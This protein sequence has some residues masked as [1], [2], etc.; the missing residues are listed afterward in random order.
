MSKAREL[1]KLPNYVLSTVA[2][3]KLSVGK[4]QGDKAFVGGYY[5]DG[6]GGGGDFYWD[7]VSVETDN[8]GTIFQVTGT[9]TGRWKRIYSGSVNV[10]WFGA[11]GD[12]A[13]NDTAAIQSSMQHLSIFIPIGKY[14]VTTPLIPLSK[15]KIYG[16]GRNTWYPYGAVSFPDF[17][18]SALIT[19]G[20]GC[21]NLDGKS[22]VS[23][24][25]ISIEDLSGVQSAYG[26]NAGYVVGSYGIKIPNTVSIQI[27]DIS[28][29]GLEY[30]IMASE[31]IDEAEAMMFR[32]DNFEASDCKCV[33][34]IGNDTSSG[35]IARDFQ[36]LNCT[37]ALHCGT[38][39]DVSNTDGMQCTNLRLFQS[40]YDAVK[41]KN[42]PFVVMNGITI[43]ESKERNIIIDGCNY[44]VMSAMLLSRA[45]GYSITTPWVVKSAIEIIN[46]NSIKFDGAIEHPA[47]QAIVLSSCNGANID[48]T[49]ETPFYTNGMSTVGGEGAVSI[50]SSTG[51][52]L[53]GV[54]TGD[55]AYIYGVK[56]DYNSM[57]EI[58]GYV[59]TPKYTANSKVYS[60]DT[61][62]QLC[63]NYIYP[64]DVALGAGGGASV[65]FV[66]IYIPNGK[67]LVT[68]GGTIGNKD[69]QF[70]ILYGAGF[71]F[72][73]GLIIDE[74]MYSTTDERKEIYANS[75]GS[76]IELQLN[77]WDRNPTAGV[78]TILA[79]TIYSLNFALE[80]I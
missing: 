58:D 48:F 62:N 24:S 79:G 77:L 1:S 67:K 47:G 33:V 80:N 20:N 70:R 60:L 7:A 45:G 42:S 16:E 10:K 53:N 72:T 66:K 78:V 50:A 52:I 28:F 38:F 56:S 9:T 19:N 31:I 68:R 34:K 26:A 23:I 13:T 27:K 5:A 12:G 4:E 49:A 65:G 44:I 36:I 8:G 74:N 21:F 73:S 32:L 71:F 15:S 29:S 2:E 64:T 43:F 57:R 3:L 61:K 76:S 54:M 14:L 59:K 75:T 41:I 55:N 11:K 22:N 17:R 51:V 37:I 39:L 46:T 25:S 63:F 6:D 69:V 40:Y 18:R 30:G 35:Y